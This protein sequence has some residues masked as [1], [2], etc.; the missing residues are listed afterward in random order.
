MRGNPREYRMRALRCAELAVAARAPQLKA[1]FLALSKNWE[2]PAI[3]L[4]DA[5][6]KRTEKILGRASKSRS[7]RLNGSVACPSGRNRP[8]RH[9]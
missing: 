7:M 9:F 5:F 1:T 8:I 4:E 3:Q 2:K 6:A